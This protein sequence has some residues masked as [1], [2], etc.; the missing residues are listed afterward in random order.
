VSAFRERGIEISE[1]A[2]N[3]NAMP[4][5]T[6]FPFIRLFGFPALFGRQAEH[7]EIRAVVLSGFDLS[8]FSYKTN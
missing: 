1:L 5:G 2:E 4:L 3:Q 7:R 6:R 8:V